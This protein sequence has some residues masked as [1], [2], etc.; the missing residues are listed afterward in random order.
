[1]MTSQYNLRE[2]VGQRGATHRVDGK[3]NSATRERSRAAGE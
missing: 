1:M 3:V 2:K